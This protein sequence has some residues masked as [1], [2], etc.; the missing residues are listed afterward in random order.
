MVKTAQPTNTYDSTITIHT[1]DLP[2]T[3]EI[4][5]FEVRGATARFYLGSKED[6][7]GYLKKDAY[8]GYL[9]AGLAEK[10]VDNLKATYTGDDWD[11]KPYE[12]NA[13]KVYNDYIKGVREIYF[14]F[15]AV[16]LEP[17]YG[18][19]ACAYSKEDFK[20]RV[21]PC[22]IY[23]TD[24]DYYLDNFANTYKE[25]AADKD[26]RV[27]KFYFGDEAT[28]GKY[29]YLEGAWGLYLG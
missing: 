17:T 3:G 10:W 2:F 27:V 24:E 15:D 19:R 18:K 28:E 25:W 12:D 13:G 1:A 21:V 6:E 22:L 29:I 14:P 9:E 26:P 11:D 20:N 5:D 16:I 23:I 8:L 7:Y 4:I